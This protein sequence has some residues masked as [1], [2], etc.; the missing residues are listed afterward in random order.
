M[1]IFGNFSNLAGDKKKRQIQNNS[2]AEFELIEPSLEGQTKISEVVGKG[3]M[4][5]LK[6]ILVICFVFLSYRLFVLQIVD[7][8]KNRDLAQGNS[9]RP[10]AILS[11]RGVIF[12]SKG[13][14]LARNKPSFALGV[15]PSD[16]PIEKKERLSVLSRLSE[17]SAVS[18]SEIEK[19][20]FEAGSASIQAV[21]IKADLP[22]EEALILE[23]KTF[24]L[25]GVLIVEQA[26]REYQS[27]SGLAHILGYTLPISAE[28]KKNNPN[29]I[30]SEQYGKLGIEK[31]YENNLRGLPGI[32]EVEVD[33]KGKVVR[34]LLGNGIREPVSGD[35]I[36]LNINLDLQNQMANDL[37]VG[38]SAAGAD[39][40]SGVA[41]AINPNTGAV[42]GLVSLPSYDNNIFSGEVDQNQYQALLNDPNLPLLNRATMGAYPSGSVIKIVMAAAGLEDGIITKN[43]SIET[44]PEITVGE[45]KFPD[46]KWHTGM[47]NVTRALAESNDI[48]FY[49]LSG[50][51]DK[52]SGLGVEKIAK[53]LSLFGFGKKTGIDLASESTGLVPT[54]EWKERVKK[55]N[56]Y[57]GNTY[58]VGIGQGDFL[59]TPIQMAKALLPFANGGK[60]L[61]PQ[62]VKE[63]TN[64]NEEVV[65]KFSPVVEKEGFISA[66]NIKTVQEGMRQT[67]LYGSARTMADLPVSSAAKT[68]TA[69]FLNNQKMHA[70]FV[71]YAPYE[72]PEIA[73]VV[74]V[75]GG[76][77]GNEVALPVAKSILSW[78][79]ANK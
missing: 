31:V 23:E 26:T 51:F 36:I 67:V 30:S 52:I 68:G 46:W 37:S 54:P 8:S 63:I 2:L 20:I 76:G 58:H 62:I 41:I 77:Q 73:V 10:R 9:I 32:E 13:R 15:Y 28:E 6:F 3:V 65:K 12:D 78:Y 56:W 14:W 40:H 48:F 11:S 19:K 60:L 43:T 57:I 79:F 71:T 34:T 50:G 7:A 38:I 49:A 18:V 72:N 55:E 70:W 53:Y 74:L 44:P 42:L 47:T 35:N 39:V 61:T 29:Y 24:G 5:F 17:I 21:I 22:R 45:Y 69:Q 1:D 4:P 33:S 64:S 16:L 66:E 27:Q 25:S 75:D 59:T